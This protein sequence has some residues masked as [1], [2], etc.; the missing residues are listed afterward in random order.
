LRYIWQHIDTILKTYDGSLPLTHFLKN[1]FRQHP[2]LGSRDRKVLS[3]MAYC[4]YRSEKGLSNELTQEEKIHACLTL[5]NSKGKHIVSFLQTTEQH[6]PFNLE[7]LFPYGI[8][9]SSGVDK[10][11]WL[12][13]MLVQPRMFIRIRS[14]NAGV[15][16]ILTD[17]AITFEIISDNCLS[18]PNGSTVDKLLDPTYYVVQDASSQQTGNFFTPQKHQKWWDCCSGA[19]GKSLLLK[20]KESNIYLTVS[21]TRSSIL[22]NLKER[23]KLYNHKVPSAHVLDI[24]DALA[25]QKTLGNTLFE[26]IICDVPCTGSGT[27][28]RTP[29]QLYFFNPLMVKGIA[30]LQ[31][32]IAVNA[33]NYLKAGGT[34]YYITCSVFKEENE[35]VLNHL[36]ETN[37]DITCVSSQL[38]NGINTHADNMYIAVLKKKTTAE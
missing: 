10:L 31:K 35:D 23:F 16:K 26:G 33:S 12:R 15:I 6:S 37:K 9:L 14:N 20:D 22:H 27:W 17:N 7:V 2:K 25:T 8:E 5:C 1:Y 36:L 32:N 11:S 34:M 38:I 30:A 29:E 13:S 21:D 18:L 28:A 3:E 19:G 4:W 24:A